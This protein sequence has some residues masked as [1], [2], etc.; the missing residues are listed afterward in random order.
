[1]PT[2]LDFGGVPGTVA[3]DAIRDAVS[4]IAADG[5]NQAYPVLDLGS[6]AWLIDDQIDIPVSQLEIRNGKITLAQGA[7]DWTG[8]YA[9][10]PSSGTSRVRFSRMDL[11]CN[12]L[13]NGIS[14][15]DTSGMVVEDVNIWRYRDVG[16]TYTGGGCYYRNFNILKFFYTDPQRAKLSAFTGTGLL[17]DGVDGRIRD[18]VSY[19]G[20]FPLDITSNAHHM[21]IVGSHCW[22][23]CA[24][25]QTFTGSGTGPFVVTSF[26]VDSVAH[27]RVKKN[28]T[29]L[30]GGNY[31]ATLDALGYASITLS[32]S[33]AGGTLTVGAR[34]PDITI[35]RNK[36]YAIDLDS[37][38]WDQG[39]MLIYNSDISVG[40]VSLYQSDFTD[41][42]AQ[43]KFI[44]TAPGQA[45]KGLK[46]SVRPASGI[47]QFSFGTEGSG[48]W[49]SKEVIVS[50]KEFMGLPR[51]GYTTNA[52]I[53]PGAAW[54]AHHFQSSSAR[55]LTVPKD[56][57]QGQGALVSIAGGGTLTIT[58]ETGA[59]VNNAAS[60]TIS[61][62]K[63]H[64]L[65]CQR[66]Y[67]SEAAEWFVT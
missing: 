41:I 51:I 57:E 47:G 21:R 56:G 19:G 13:G 33:L 27:L 9:F 46:W 20:A 5:A 1:M 66:N 28:G 4:A 2:P 26:Q 6:K 63:L 39:Q 12:Y 16:L 38:Y 22:S 32:S 29:V 23:G 50:D 14:D 35:M 67:P 58:A 31:S 42:D 40:G 54:T 64:V 7:S 36:G 60:V 17:V 8:K 62:G 48:S 59:K 45:T 43:V 53:Y 34:L 11:W 37:G 44:A 18:F 49:A 61:D 52:S 65:S 15:Q 55:V 24:D 30:A 10:R 25:T 3:T